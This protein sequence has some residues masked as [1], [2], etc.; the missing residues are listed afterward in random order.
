MRGCMPTKT[1]L[2]SAH[3]N[4]EIGRAK[5]FGIRVGKPRP[6]WKAILRRKDQL[7]A[8]FADY[9]QEQFEKGKFTFTVRMG[10]LRD[11]TG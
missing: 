5:E 6:D 8:E 4:H 1:M 7:I 9:R 3:R 11:L 2:E 10:V